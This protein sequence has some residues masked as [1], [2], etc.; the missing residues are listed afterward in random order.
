MCRSASLYSI[1]RNRAKLRHYNVGQ[2]LGHP[3]TRIA[4]RH[5]LCVLRSLIWKSVAAGSPPANPRRDE[6]DR[7]PGVYLRGNSHR[8]P[9]DHI[10]ALFDVSRF[11]GLPRLARIAAG[12]LN[13]KAGIAPT[14]ETH[15]PAAI[16]K[17]RVVGHEKMMAVLAVRCPPSG[18]SDRAHRSYVPFVS[19][20]HRERLPDWHA[21]S[22][23][24]ALNV[25]GGRQDI[26]VLNSGAGPVRIAA[27]ALVTFAIA[28]IRQHVYTTS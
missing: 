22:G 16:G 11:S 14:L 1:H 17:A 25:T 7:M 26:A 21:V 18:T 2:F 4:Q 5:M 24:A 12:L 3:W 28:V 13:L 19:A 6:L 10:E 8:R 23:T 15:T 9:P 20:I 27:V